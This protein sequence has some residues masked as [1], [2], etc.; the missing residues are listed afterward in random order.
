M[1]KINTYI[2]K[3]FFNNLMFITNKSFYEPS[4]E[5]YCKLDKWI[6]LNS[7]V[8]IT[9]FKKLLKYLY[10]INLSNKK[11]KKRILFIIDENIIMFF[12]SLPSELCYFSSTIKESFDFL[13]NKELYNSVSCIVYI[14]N[15]DDVNSLKFT[16]PFIGF[17]FQNTKFFDYHS[18]TYTFFHS[19]LVLLKTCLVSV[20]K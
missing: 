2:L 11:T 13:S 16:L 1:K 12:S 20:L 9:D 5:L 18:S 14:G 6:I 8:S 10:L 17:T 15:D 7:E 19:T 4:T 3:Y